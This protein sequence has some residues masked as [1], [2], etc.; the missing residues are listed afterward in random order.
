MLA[1]VNRAKGKDTFF[2]TGTDEHGYKQQI[3]AKELKTTPQKL[4]DENVK[5]FKSL[6]K[7]LG[8]S[9][10]R[11]IRTTE[12]SHK[13]AAQKLWQAC[14]KDIYKSDYSG[15]YCVGCERFIT[16][17]EL[18]D[19]KCPEHNKAPQ[20]L[21]MESYFFKLSNYTRQ[22]EK[23]IESD[24]LRVTPQSRKNEILAL[25]R[26][27]LEDVS[28]SRPKTQLD[29]G[30]EVPGDPDHV[31]YV[32]YD[33]L[34]NYIS[35]VGYEED[36]EKFQKFWPA[37][38]HI[39]GKDIVRFHAA[40]WPAMLISAGLKIPKAVYAHG[41][42]AGK[43]GQKMSK[44]LGNVID[45]GEVI[46]KYGSDALRYYLLRE[47]PWDQD[48]EFS[49]E[50]LQ[51]VYDADLANDLGNLVQRVS[52]MI[53]KYLDG[54]IGK[55]DALQVDYSEIEPI[56]E[57]YR[58]NDALELIWKRIRLA[59]QKIDTEK[60]WELFKSDKDKLE[61]LLNDL[62]REIFVIACFAAPFLPNTGQKIFK[63]F[64]VGKVK[65]GEILFPKKDA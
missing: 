19:G 60:P 54:K 42:I 38:L 35:A 4:A 63:Q 1:R 6:Y 29:W 61:K 53:E 9:Y 65:P 27:G 24:E 31:M 25:V 14:E 26:G 59:N 5:H 20:K 62:S 18:A 7:D 13:K 49:W 39:I 3:T 17:K 33:A 36:E 57:A 32:W 11:F 52:N 46:K 51:Q 56:L 21:T 58:F 45:P 40:L 10:D 47:V 44:S 15:L 16:E 48:G 55:L 28:I 8:I 30:V 22:I 64:T 23:L 12:A 37:D 34:S 43:G 2:L 50:R 41:F